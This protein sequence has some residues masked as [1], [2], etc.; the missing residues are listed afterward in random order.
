VLDRRHERDLQRLPGDRCLVRIDEV[1]RV[2]VKPQDIF[3]YRRH[4]GL[5]ISGGRDVRRQQ[6]RSAT[7]Q[8]VKTRVRGDAVQPS[9]QRP[10]ALAP[11]PRPRPPSARERVLYEILGV[12]E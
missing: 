11:E 12:V 6:A 8:M 10:P 9:A 7:R 1:V 5:R 2:R 3:G 4:V